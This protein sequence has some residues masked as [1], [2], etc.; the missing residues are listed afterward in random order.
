MEQ[1]ERPQ[2]YINDLQPVNLETKSLVDTLYTLQDNVLRGLN[3]L[4][5]VR[6]DPF[7]GSG[8]G[9]SL[10]NE[11]GGSQTQNDTVGTITKGNIGR[12]RM[13]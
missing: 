11:M 9:L 13:L 10:L 6:P 12:H 1:V 3:M 7:L 8:P 5:A 2:Y 4:Q